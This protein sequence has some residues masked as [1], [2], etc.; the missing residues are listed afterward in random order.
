MTVTAC[1]ESW[2]IGFPVQHHLRGVAATDNNTLWPHKQ[3][4]SPYIEPFNIQSIY[5]GE[6]VRLIFLSSA[7]PKCI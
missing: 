1:M 3:F 4:G 7:L 2:F 5:P 6:V